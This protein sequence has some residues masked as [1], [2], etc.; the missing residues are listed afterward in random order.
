MQ[1]SA[2]KPA[3]L[4]AQLFIAI[5]FFVLPIAA[6]C[7]RISNNS[8]LSAIGK[9]EFISNVYNHFEGGILFRD[10]ENGLDILWS[11]SFKGKRVYK[12]N[13]AFFVP[14]GLL[15]L[16]NTE[17]TTRSA[18]L[19]ALPVQIREGKVFVLFEGILMPVLGIVHTHID[20]LPEPTPRNDY[21]YGYMGIHNYI[22]SYAD[23]F[24][25]FKNSQGNEVCNR[26]G[27]RSSVAKIVNGLGLG[28]PSED[29]LV[30]KSTK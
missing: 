21:Q 23:L 3:S 10:V 28:L 22:M 1:N 13:A 5:S 8:E 14:D 4:R 15:I 25:A 19:S 9:N 7:Q 12:E 29:V 16:P 27:S 6:L 11:A 20:G 17:N 2:L 24:D 26:L 18:T 30:A